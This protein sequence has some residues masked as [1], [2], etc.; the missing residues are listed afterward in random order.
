MGESRKSNVKTRHI[1][2][3]ALFIILLILAALI[4]AQAV[5]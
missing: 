4:L 1:P 5:H 2:L 3:P